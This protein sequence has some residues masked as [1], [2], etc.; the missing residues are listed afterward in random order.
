MF[1]QV[2]TTGELVNEGN[3]VVIWGIADA[4]VETIEL[5][6]TDGA[7]NTGSNNIVTH[8]FTDISPVVSFPYGIQ[9]K[10]G[11]SIAAGDVTVFY[12]KI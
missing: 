3:P 2:M 5:N 1:Y 6:D 7:G 12:T 4:T 9:A 8:S 11:A 10:D